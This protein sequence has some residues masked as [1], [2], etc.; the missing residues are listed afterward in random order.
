VTIGGLIVTHGRLG[1]I[2]V[3]ETVRITGH[4][5]RLDAMRTDGLSAGE[6]TARVRDWIGD[7]PWV[8]FTDSKGTAPTIRSQA[9]IRPGQVV[10]SGVNLGMLLSF[11]FHR[12]TQTV[13]ELAVRLIRDGHRCQEVLWPK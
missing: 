2:F 13:E 5:E 3:E 4:T 12:E 7:D 8:V 6:I 9:A 10:I 1:E 11:I